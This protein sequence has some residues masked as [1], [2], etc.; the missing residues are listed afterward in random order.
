MGL[1]NQTLRRI[2][3]GTAG[4]GNQA[5]LL[6]ALLQGGISRRTDNQILQEW[7][8]AAASGNS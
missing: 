7:Q 6:S 3:V 2:T 8:E 5:V 1:C 4:T